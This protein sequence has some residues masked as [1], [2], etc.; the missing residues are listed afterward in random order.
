MLLYLTVMDLQYLFLQPNVTQYV[1]KLTTQHCVKNVRMRSYSC[2]YFPALDEYG[3]ICNISPYSVRIRENAEQNNS[4][5]GH[6]SRNPGNQDIVRGLFIFFLVLLRA[7]PYY[8][9]SCYLSSQI[10][11]VTK[12]TGKHLYQSLAFN[13]IADVSQQLYEKRDSNTGVFR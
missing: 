11:S 6:F 8:F 4:E 3:E 12:F 5:Y 9:Q 10:N 13:K 7:F 1:L 2:P